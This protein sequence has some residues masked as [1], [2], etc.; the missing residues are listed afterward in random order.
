MVP[1]KRDG[2]IWIALSAVVLFVSVITLPD[3][4]SRRGPGAGEAM[5]EMYLSIGLIA[6]CFIGFA[7]GIYRLISK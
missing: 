3:L 1:E 4:Y 2:V 5:P 6:V 7:Y